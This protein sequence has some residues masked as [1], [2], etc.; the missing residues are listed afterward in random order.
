MKKAKEIL[1]EL[2]FKNW[3]E[4]K[5]FIITELE[6]NYGKRTSIRDIVKFKGIEDQLNHFSKEELLSYIIVYKSDIIPLSNPNKFAT[7]VAGIRLEGDI[8]SI[9]EILDSPNLYAGLAGTFNIIGDAY[10]RYRLLQSLAE[11]E[12]GG[13]Q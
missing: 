5:N 11:I 2:E 8:R 7:T 4:L 1:S 10:D 3:E 9:K 13:D 12:E 6:K